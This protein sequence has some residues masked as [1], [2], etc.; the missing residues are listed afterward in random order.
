[1]KTVLAIAVGGSLG[2]LA[3]YYFSIGAAKYFGTAFPWGTLLENFIGCFV[4]GILTALMERFWMPSAEIKAFLTIG[5]LGAFT[6]FSAFSLD[7]ALLHE[8]GELLVGGLYVLASV[9][10]SI[11]GIFLGMLLIRLISQ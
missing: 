10:A 11:G 4:M 6:T 3:R 1:M 2:A 8:R 9:I 7:F 5:F